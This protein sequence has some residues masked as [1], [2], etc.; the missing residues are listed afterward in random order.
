MESLENA[1]DVMR[2]AIV[3]DMTLPWIKGFIDEETTLQRFHRAGIDFV[4]LTVNVA[5][6]PLAATIH[7][8]A[9]V[10]AQILAHGEQMVLAVSAE[11]IEAAKAAGRLAVGLHFQSTEPLERSVELVRTF[12]DLGVRHML[13]AYNQKNAVG[14][15]CAERTDS[16]LSRY[17][18]QLIAEMN[19]VGV[20]VD[21]SHTGYRTT[22]EAM[23][24]CKGPFI[25]SHSNAYALVPHYRNIRDDQIRACARSGGLIGINGVNEFLGDPAASTEAIFRHVDHVSHLVGPRHVGIG[26]DYVQNLEAVWKWVQDD[27]SLWPDNN[28]APPE[29]PAHGQPEQIRELAALMLARGYSREDVGNIL[30][31]NFLRVMRAACATALELDGTHARSAS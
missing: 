16:G 20:L 4:S 3:C 22:M 2:G 18:I 1:M 17:G 5:E 21:G 15:G 8:I 27:R 12:H 23:E 7:H 13:L 19:R 25:F 10:R 30:G 14:D 11:E 24:A 31:G 6:N 26:L 9:K 28:G 29:Y